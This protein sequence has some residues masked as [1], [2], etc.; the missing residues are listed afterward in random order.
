ML[1]VLQ[2]V[3][4]D[5]DLKEYYHCIP[6]TNRLFGGKV[7]PHPYRCASQKHPARRQ[8]GLGPAFALFAVYI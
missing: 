3:D 8:Q 7:P 2:Q 1:D 5:G 6:S 4:G